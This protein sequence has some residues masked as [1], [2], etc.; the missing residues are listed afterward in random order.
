[1]MLSRYIW[2]PLGFHTHTISSLVRRT[3]CC[4]WETVACSITP[5]L[6]PPHRHSNWR[7]VAVEIP[8]NTWWI[9]KSYHLLCTANDEI[10][11]MSCSWTLKSFGAHI[12]ACVLTLRKCRDWGTAGCLMAS[13]LIQSACT[14]KQEDVTIK[15][16][17]DAPAFRCWYLRVYTDNQRLVWG[18][19]YW[20]PDGFQAHISLLWNK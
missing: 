20:I 6:I 16:Q 14:A 8:L 9:L 17:L 11:P 10:L 2:V 19:D 5:M 12:I 18:R 15:R 1:M 4:H 3:R 13:L 7:I